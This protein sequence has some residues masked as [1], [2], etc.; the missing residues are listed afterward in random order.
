[1]Q[2]REAYA[3][4][5][6]NGETEQQSSGVA[7]RF[8]LRFFLA[9][10]FPFA[11]V[12]VLLCSCSRPT[13]PSGFELIPPQYA[14]VFFDDLDRSSLTTATLQSLSA[15]QKK[16]DAETLAFGEKRLPIA[17]V[18]ASLEAFLA[19]LESETELPARLTQ[20]FAVYRVTTPVLFTGY[21]EPVLNGS[22]VRTERYRYPLYRRPDDLV[23][24]DLAAFFPER[25]GEKVYGRV[26]KDKLFPY[27]SRAEID[28]QG[29]FDGKQYELAWVDDP[30]ARFFLHI[31]GSGQIQLPDGTRL[32]IGYAATNGKPYTSIGKVLLQQGKLRAGQTSAPAI[33]RYLYTH[34]TEQDRIFFHNARY[35]FFQLVPDGPRGSLGVPLTPGRSLATDP[36]IY[37]PGALGFIRTKRPIVAQ[38]EHVAWQE[39]SRFVLFQDS[40]AAI[41]GW[42]RADLFWG[43]EGESE[44]GYMAQEGELFVLLKKP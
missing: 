29:V 22:L 7:K 8:F 19:L 34:P 15:L 21:Y 23:E 42:N 1:M 26:E 31:Q 16:S 10:V 18:R 38:N 44:A 41:T 30:V 27:F 13:P 5:S 4:R 14:P 3:T 25:A 39:F 11:F 28:G 32:R 43:S 24:V 33:R 40:G 2:Q 37:P 9:P 6:G 35:V 20:E 12:F 36:R 17:Q